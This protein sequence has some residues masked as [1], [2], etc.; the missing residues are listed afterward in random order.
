MD[1]ITGAHNLTGGLK[2]KVND[3]NIFKVGQFIKLPT[4]NEIPEK[5]KLGEPRLKNQYQSD[6]C[7]GFSGAGQSEFQEGTELSPEYQFA[8]A[9]AVEGDVEGWG[10]QLVSVCKSLVKYGSIPK[11]KAKYSLE[12]ESPAF[13]RDLKNWDEGLLLDAQRHKKQSYFEVKGPYDGFDDVRATMWYFREEKVAVLMGVEW[14]WDLSDVY[15]DVQKDG[16]GHAMY[17]IG[18]DGDYLMVV[19]SAGEKAG[20]RGIHYIHRNIINRSV[21]LWGAYGVIDTPRNAIEYHIKTETYM[22]DDW[23]TVFIKQIINILCT[24]KSYLKKS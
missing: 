9:K 7:G 18:W 2:K 11:S 16:F 19:N 21:D 8:L 23:V 24:I 5:F 1:T 10:V 12:N 4:L 13:L 15:I 22:K 20:D 17:V 14:G 6:F 3:P